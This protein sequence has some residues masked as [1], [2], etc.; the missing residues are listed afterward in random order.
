MSRRKAL[1]AVLAVVAG[2]MLTSGT[3][4]A[5]QPIGPNQSF[6][7]VVNGS[8]ANPPV[9]VICPGPIFPSSKGHPTGNQ[10][11]EVVLGGSGLTGS[12]GTRIAATFTADSSAPVT[13]T[14]Y[15]VP[16]AVPTSL[17]LPCAGAGLAVFT[18]QPASPTARSATVTVRFIN[19]AV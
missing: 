6:S 2:L 18:P 15:G 19:L 5:Q 13:F 11:W 4:A 3:A 8:M 9:Y 12:A 14:E 16:K 17:L 10:S 7:G 1:T